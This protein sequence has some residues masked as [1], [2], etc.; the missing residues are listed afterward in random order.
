MDLTLEKTE[1]N[2]TQFYTNKVFEQK[3]EW[4]TEINTRTMSPDISPCNIREDNFD[5]HDSPKTSS[6]ER[7]D[8]SPRVDIFTLNSPKTTYFSCQ[9]NNIIQKINRV[10]KTKKTTPPINENIIE[11]ILEKV[12]NY[13]QYNNLDKSHRSTEEISTLADT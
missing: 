1:S 6:P 9:V 13:I 2:E 3:I 11:K 5:L 7:K 10:V 8:L 4:E 12:E